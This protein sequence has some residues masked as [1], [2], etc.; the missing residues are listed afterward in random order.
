MALL[1]RMAL[2]LAHF[3][4]LQCLCLMWVPDK[5][6]TPSP[7]YLNLNTVT[8]CKFQN[9]QYVCQVC[10]STVKTH[11]HK[12]LYGPFSGLRRWSSARRNFLNFMVQGKITDADTLTIR[13]GT[14]PS[15]LISDPPPSSLHF[16]AGCPSCCNPPN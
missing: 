12:P 6:V 9:C 3:F 2:Q 4:F 8:L 7:R 11:V 13:M 14:T 10:L 15:V 5:S 1:L 16:C